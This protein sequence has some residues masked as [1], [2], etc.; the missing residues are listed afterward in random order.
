MNFLK[1]VTLHLTN[2]CNLKCRHCW[3]D[4]S[5]TQ[6]ENSIE[7][8]A[9]KSVLIQ[10]KE[11]EVVSVKLTGGEPFMYNN[12]KELLLFLGEYGFNVSI[13]TNLTLID[14]ESLD[15]IVKY[16]FYIATSLDSYES[17]Y[18]DWFRK[19][20]GCFNKTLDNIR[21][22]KERNVDFQIIWSVTRENKDDIY[23]M[24]DFC[25]KEKIPT[26]KINPV[27]RA[28]RAMKSADDYTIMNSFERLELLDIIR[29]LRREYSEIHISYP[30]PPA[31]LRV[32]ELSKYSSECDICSRCII[33]DNGDVGLCGLNKSYPSLLYGNI[34]N[35][36][37]KEIIVDADIV[38]SCNKIVDSIVGVC[39]KCIH[40][41]HCKGY[42]RANAVFVSNDIS[43]P[44][45]LCQD[46]YNDGRFPKNRLRN[47]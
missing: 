1:H 21:I 6:K 5:I 32:D 13:E 7:I 18:H 31:F 22:L 37:F 35:K 39:S 34:Y 4:A 27:N 19:R 45:V 41:S 33:L 11:L 25:R 20:Y 38:S 8:N 9:L 15:I 40:I 26:I 47:M 24:L 17:G 28:G 36:S 10:A 43:A 14:E 46:I 44:Y 42:C 16:G 2:L 3:V 30:I 23:H 12:I 29:E